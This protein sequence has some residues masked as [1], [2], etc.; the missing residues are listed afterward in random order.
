[1]AEKHVVGKFDNQMLWEDMNEQQ[2]AA[3]LRSQ[4][5]TLDRKRDKCASRLFF[6]RNMKR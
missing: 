2:R 4:V 6:A 5:L 1:M 3:L